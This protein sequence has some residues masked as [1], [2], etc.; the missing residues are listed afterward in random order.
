MRHSISF[1]HIFGLFLH[2]PATF[3]Q[4]NVV[5]KPVFEEWQNGEPINCNTTKSY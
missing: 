5:P 4:T 1:H 3:A 2:N